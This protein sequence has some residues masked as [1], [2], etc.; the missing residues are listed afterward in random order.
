MGLVL[1][2]A[3]GCTFTG[4]TEA[5]VDPTLDFTSSTSGRTWWND[6]GLLKSHY[7]AIAFAAYNRGNLE[8]DLAR[9]NGEYAA[10]LGELFG[11]GEQSRPVFHATAQQRFEALAPINPMQVQQLRSL[12]E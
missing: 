3:T 9:G 12:V 7:K 11:L 5:T 1:A 6:D 2:L 8:Q 4:T 10:S